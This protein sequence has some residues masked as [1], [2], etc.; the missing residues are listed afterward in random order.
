[1]NR[2]LSEL[3][4]RY[5]DGDLDDAESSRLETQAESDP[6]LAAEIDA[7]RRIRAAVQTLAGRMEP[8]AALDRVMEPLRQGPPVPTQRTRPVYRWL[9]IAAAVVLGVTVATEMVRRNPTPAPSRTP[10]QQERRVQ[11]SEKIFEL[12]PLPTAVPD[13]HRPLGAADHLLEEEPALPPAPEPAALEVM[14]PLNTAARSDAAV[15]PFSSTDDR[16]STADEGLASEFAVGARRSSAKNEPVSRV[17]SSIEAS[18]AAPPKKDRLQLD[19]DLQSEAGLTGAGQPGREPAAGGALRAAVSVTLRIDGSAVWSG[20]SSAC[21]VGR[22]S[23]RIEVR[24]H[25]VSNLEPVVVEAQST[26][27]AVCEPDGLIGSSFEGVSD[28]TYL[29]ELVIGE[30]PE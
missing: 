24:G 5:A 29:G 8:P 27:G 10:A 2:A 7:T 21:Q 17:G 28:G 18:A 16:L 23:V 22:I 14:G 15:E 11:A 3:V 20:S 9:G 13:D 26:A 1:M 30:S 6:E 4:S 19:G 12:A 25:V